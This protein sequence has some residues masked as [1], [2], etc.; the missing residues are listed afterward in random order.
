[1]V[2]PVVFEKVDGRYI[3]RPEDAPLVPDYRL[4]DYSP[5]SFPDEAAARAMYDEILFTR[6]VH[7]RHLLTDTQ[8]NRLL[9]YAAEMCGEKCVF[10]GF[11]VQSDE[12]IDGRN[13]DINWYGTDVGTRQLMHNAVAKLRKTA[14][15]LDT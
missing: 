3:W 14:N 15:L 9:N 12:H 10:K 2:M 8:L 5:V 4:L 1:M 13:W 7:G 6:H 11:V